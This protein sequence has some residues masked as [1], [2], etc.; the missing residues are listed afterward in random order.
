[1][2]PTVGGGG[3]GR[4]YGR[5]YA[6]VAAGFQLVVVLLLFM[7]LGWFV[8]GRLGLRPLFTI[9]GALVGAALGFYSLYLRVERD[10]ERSRRER[11]ERSGRDEP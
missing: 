4:E 5:G 2:C 11:Q 6:Y 3:A 7:A 10:V 1:M 8:D 9:A